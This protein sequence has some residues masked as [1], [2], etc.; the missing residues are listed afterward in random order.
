MVASSMLRA[1]EASRARVRVDV[2]GSG[3]Y[4][5]RAFVVSPVAHGRESGSIP[6]LSS[7]R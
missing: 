5:G 6:E 2:P 4:I 1:R 3:G 7:Q